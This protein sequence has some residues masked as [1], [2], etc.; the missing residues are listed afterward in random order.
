[1][2]VIDDALLQPVWQPHICL[3]EVHTQC[4]CAIELAI[5][6]LVARNRHAARVVEAYAI[7]GIAGDKHARTG[8]S[9]RVEGLTL[10]QAGVRVD[11]RNAQARDAVREPY[12]AKVRTV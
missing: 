2:C 1:M 6:L 10:L 12:A 3:E 4:A 8:P 11:R 5:E 9:P 7:E